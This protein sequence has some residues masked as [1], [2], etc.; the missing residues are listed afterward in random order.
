MT[1]GWRELLRE[2]HVLTKKTTQCPQQGLEP[3]EPLD[4]EAR[5]LAM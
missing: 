3:D 4:P 1:P 5:A 2:L